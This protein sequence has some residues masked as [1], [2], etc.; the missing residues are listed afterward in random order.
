MTKKDFELIAR[1]LKDARKYHGKNEAETIAIIAVIDVL[2]Y[3]FADELKEVNPRFDSERF[4]VACETDWR[5]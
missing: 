2:G 4:L 1:V 3:R 5:K